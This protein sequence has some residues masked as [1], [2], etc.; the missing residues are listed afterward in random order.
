MSNVDR[1]AKAS[2]FRSFGENGTFE[3]QCWDF[4]LVMSHVPY[5]KADVAKPVL[6]AIHRVY[7]PRRERER[8]REKKVKKGKGRLM[9]N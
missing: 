8:E 3:S 7:V 6:R 5:S 4:I 1:Y 2:K 9:V